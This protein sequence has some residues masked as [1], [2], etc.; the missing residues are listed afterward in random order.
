[1]ELHT[2]GVDGGYTQKDVTELAKVLTGWTVKEPRR[3]GGYEFNERM[4]QPGKKI[5]LGREFKDDGEHEGEKALEML[6]SN[7]S[8]AR[9]IST[10]LAMRFVSDDPPK[11][12][13]DRMAQT[14]TKSDGDIRE[15]LR[16]MFKSSEFW[17][18]ASYRAKVKTPLEFVVS[19]LRATNADV[20]NAMPIAQ[21]LNRMGMPLYSMQP[22]T[23]YSMKAETWVNSAALLNRMNTAIALGAGRM[24][25]VNV[26]AQAALPPNIADAGQ[27]QDAL[28]KQ[29]LHGDISQQTHETIRKQLADPKITERAYD[30]PARVPNP[31]VIAGLILGSPEFQRR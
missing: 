26:N 7:P 28:E 8:T 1:M 4:H 15:V 12:L 13:I 11:S 20:S 25:G 5:V 27:I 22:P 6:A 29:L 19:A 24:Q 16:T 31:G 23:G 10:K 18:P 21:A 14:F 9:F 2:L 3:G 30:D 17:S